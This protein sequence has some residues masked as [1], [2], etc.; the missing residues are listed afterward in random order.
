[1]FLQNIVFSVPGNSKKT[2]HMRHTCHTVAGFPI[3]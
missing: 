2:R 3:A 1:M